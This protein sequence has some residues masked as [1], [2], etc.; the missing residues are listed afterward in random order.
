[1]NGR[2]PEQAAPICAAFAIGAAALISP[3]LAMLVLAMLGAW[4]LMRANAL[5]VDVAALA[6]PVFATLIVGAFTGLAG[7]IGVLFVWRLF[8]DTMWS[9]KEAQRL[10]LAAGKPAETSW[11]ALA[12]AWAT[13]FYGLTMVAFTAPHMIAGLPLDL[14][15]VPVWVPVAASVVA[16]G[17]V[18]DW[19]LRCAADWRLGELAKAPAAHLLVHH[20]MFVLAFGV[21]ID[22]SAGIFAMMAWRLMHAAPLRAPQASFTAVP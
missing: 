1:M 20:V 6:G 22:V 17:T 21:L 16:A 7:A 2:I 18:F 3:P 5:R 9:V 4:T 14:P 13:P 19:A 11:R 8:S 12:H 10:A 15:H